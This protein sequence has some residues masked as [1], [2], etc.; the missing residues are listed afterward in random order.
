MT[1]HSVCERYAAF[2]VS[3]SETFNVRDIGTTLRNIL[4]MN[5]I[6]PW[7]QIHVDV[8]SGGDET[9]YL[10]YPE[11]GLSISIAP[12]ALPFIKEYFT[13]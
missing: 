2:S 7:S 8:F 3:S 12:Y 5:N 11:N 1:V 13:E 9:M 4:M 10:A 6:K